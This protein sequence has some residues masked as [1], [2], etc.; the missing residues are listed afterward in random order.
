M[1]ISSRILCNRSGN[2]AAN[3]RCAYRNDSA[4]HQEYRMFSDRKYIYG[5][6]SVMEKSNSFHSGIILSSSNVQIVYYLQ[7][8]HFVIIQI[9]TCREFF[10]ANKTNV[11][12][13][14]CKPNDKINLDK[15]QIENS[16]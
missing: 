11:W 16:K 2:G 7:M 3:D 8:S 13:L 12:L 4:N 6:L 9:G 10:V 15:T 1:L 14:T 5:V